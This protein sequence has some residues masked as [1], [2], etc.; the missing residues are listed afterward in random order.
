MAGRIPVWTGAE[1]QQLWDE[2]NELS[3]LV[4]SA[5]IDLHKNLRGGAYA[6]V[7]LRKKLRSI[8]QAAAALVQKTSERDKRKRAERRLRRAKAGVA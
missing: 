7:R 5:G 4:Q 1:E 3:G 6:G 2:W 8:K